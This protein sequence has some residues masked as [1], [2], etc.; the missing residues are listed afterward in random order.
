M[1]ARKS[2][3]VPKTPDPLCAK[4][5]RYLMRFARNGTI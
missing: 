5:T 3:F 2:R 4:Y 1:D